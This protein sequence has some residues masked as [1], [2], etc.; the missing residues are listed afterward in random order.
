M[1]RRL[2]GV[3]GV[4]AA[5]LPDRM[6]DVFETVAIENPEECTT[7]PWVRPGIRLEGV[8]IVVASVVGGRAYA[9]LMN[10]AG[11]FGAVVVLFPQVYREVAVPLLYE[12]PGEVEWNDRATDGVR[13]IGVVYVLVARRAAR[14]RRVDGR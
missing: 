3:L 1:A 4:L 6:V 7:R 8:A 10:L 11:V 2:L 13:V 12:N 5:V 14:K 9:W